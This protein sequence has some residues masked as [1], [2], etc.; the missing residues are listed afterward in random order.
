MLAFQDRLESEEDLVR[1]AQLEHQ[2]QRETWALPELTVC[3]E[4]TGNLAHSVQLARKES[5]GRLVS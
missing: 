3:Q 1:G 5:R 4:R 2:D